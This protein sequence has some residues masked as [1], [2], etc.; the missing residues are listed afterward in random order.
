MRFT[1]YHFR[2]LEIPS[3]RSA[4]NLDAALDQHDS[5]IILIRLV[6]CL[7]SDED[8]MYVDPIDVEFQSRSAS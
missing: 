1:E 6:S 4:R 8:K 2:S 3:A 7:F 5:C